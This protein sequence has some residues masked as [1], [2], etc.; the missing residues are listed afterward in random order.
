MRSINKVICSGH[1][2]ADPEENGAVKFSLAVNDE[3]T[4]D[5]EKQQRTNWLPIVCFGKTGELA[6]TY[7]HKGSHVIVEG[8]IRQNVYEPPKGKK[9]TRTEVVATSL[10]FLDRKSDSAT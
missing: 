1:L 2:G 4:S 10:I 3:F 8:Q 5:G 9:Q 6:K 7:L